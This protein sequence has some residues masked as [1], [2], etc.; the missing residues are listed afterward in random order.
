MNTW[1]WYAAWYGVGF[2][3][4]YGIYRLW[5]IDEH[6]YRNI[7]PRGILILLLCGCFGFATLIMLVLI[8]GVVVAK[9]SHGSNWFT[10]PIDFKKPQIHK[11]NGDEE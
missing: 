11:Y 5:R 6:I 3:G 8:T 10:Q 1:M 2:I 7:T 4:S 9:M